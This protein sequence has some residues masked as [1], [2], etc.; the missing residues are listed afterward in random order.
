MISGLSEFE[1]YRVIRPIIGPYE[2][3]R[4]DM[5]IIHRTSLEDVDL[6][7]L[8]ALNF[9]N[10]SVKRDNKNTLVL[11]FQYDRTLLSLWNQPLKRIPL[12]QACAAVATPDFSLYPTMNPNEIRHNIYQSRWLGCTWQNYGVTVWPTMGWAEP[13]TYDICFS[14][15]ETGCIVVISTL[16]CQDRQQE[17]LDGFVELRKR[18]QPPLIIVYG[19]MIPGMTGTFI[20][21]KYEDIMV[22]KAEQL[23][24]QGVPRVF[25]IEE[26]V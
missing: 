12:F 24:M 11:M 5:P 6:D 16:G 22:R 20:H 21:F 14:G 18:I 9:K 19:D 7:R 8:N 3:D 26:V 1:K 13:S 25:T 4:F 23:R 10:L 2:L 17:F 15:V